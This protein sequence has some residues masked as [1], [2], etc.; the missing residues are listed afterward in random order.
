MMSATD[1]VAGNDVILKL[2]DVK[3]HYPILKGLLR[4]QV[5]AVKAVDGVSLEIRRGE[6]VGLVGESGSGKTS[7]ARSVLRIVNATAGSITYADDNGGRH[8]LND[9]AGEALRQIR[10]DVRMI[11]QDPHSSLDPRYT[12]GRII[13]EPILAYGTL[14][15]AAVQERVGDLLEM[16]G[17][18][19]E[20]VDR[21]PHMF[22][23]GERQRIGIARALALSPRLV[24]CD[25]AVSALD[26]SV[27]AQVINLLEDLQE[28][29]G[30][31]YLFVS[32]DLSIVRHISDR[33][34]VMYVGRLVEFGETDSLYDKPLH[35]YTEALLSAVPLA[36]P[37]ARQGRERIRLTGEVPDPANPPSG[38]RFNPR[39]RYATDR[40][41]TEEPAYREALPGRFVACHFAGELE[42]TGAAPA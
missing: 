5:G 9:L 16:V 26:V 39:C 36:D 21:Y 34:A 20:Y 27:Q 28:Q 22:S 25:E 12:V 11:F 42:L 37:A 30:L 32:H 15:G 19:R 24:V 1:A 4:R 33:V 2:V 18:R 40:C 7:L 10:R 31:T 6:T 29:T 35:P 38:C 13:A 23:G 17:L 8:I 14:K 3:V 41:R